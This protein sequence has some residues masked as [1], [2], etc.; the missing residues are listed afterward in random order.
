MLQKIHEEHRFTE[1]GKPAGGT[2]TG[3][4]IH[5]EWQNGPLGLTKEPNGAFVETVIEV[6]KGR[7]NCYQNNGFEC[8]ENALAIKYLD[9]ALSAL[10]ER[11]EKRRARGVEGTYEK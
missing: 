7:L 10:H 9:L 1:D 5:V 8:E 11:T 3:L 6:A 2:T 4:G